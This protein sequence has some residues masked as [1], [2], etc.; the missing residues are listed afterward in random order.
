MVLDG[1]RGE[2][3]INPSSRSL[4]LCRLRREEMLRSSDENA[5]YAHLRAETVDGLRMAVEANLESIEEIG[6][7]FQRGAAGIG[8]FRSE[9][10]Y[11]SSSMSPDEETQYN[12]YSRLLSL[13]S[14]FPVTIRTLDVGGD[15]LFVDRS[16]GD[17][18]CPAAREE[19]QEANPALGLRAIR[20]SLRET[21][22]FEIQLRALLRAS[23]HG[24]LRILF[25][26]ISS[27]CEMVR[28][29]EIL[30]ALCAELSGKRIP[31]DPGVAYGVMVE[32]PSAVAVADTLA[33]DVDF[34]SI[35]T[36]DLI[37]Y[38]LAIDRSNDQVAHMYEPLHP[39]VLRMIHHVVRAGHRAGIE[40]GICG[41]MAGRDRYLPVLLGLG[42]DSLSMNPQSIPLIKK[43]IR[44]SRAE[45]AE[46]LADQLLAQPSALDVRRCLREYLAGH[47]PDWPA[48]GKREEPERS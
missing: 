25:P 9:Y 12:A 26:M 38:A 8:L 1:S 15:K 21:A 24:T 11:L 45:D 10:L 5:A 27:Y 47:Y 44:A 35:G 4:A 39:A 7:A 48:F 40:V 20:F 36:N 37:Q 28:I 34:L 18:R 6:H 30:D 3:W 33:Q 14:P 2:V 41:E 42:L 46:R 31:Y 13:A 43:M 23:V 22:L 17:R 29:R 32:V 16:F 19:R